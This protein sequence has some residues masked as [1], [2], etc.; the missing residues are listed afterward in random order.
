MARIA[1]LECFEKWEPELRNPYARGRKQKNRTKN[2][3]IIKHK[4]VKRHMLNFN[5]KTIA[6]GTEVGHKLSNNNVHLTD[7]QWS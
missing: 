4:E 6:A 1:Y 2:R 3:N 5:L 7:S